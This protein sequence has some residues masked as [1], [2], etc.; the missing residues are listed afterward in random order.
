MA[1]API[2]PRPRPANPDTERA[3][4]RNPNLERAVLGA[5]LMDESNPS[6]TLKT[7]A[8]KIHAGVFSV[9]EHQIIYSRLL[10]MS[11]EKIPTNDIAVL[12]DELHKASDLQRIEAG[13]AYVASLIDGVPQRMN[14]AEH[15]RILREKFDLRQLIYKTQDIQ[16]LALTESEPAEKLYSDLETF[17]KSVSNARTPGLAFVDLRDFLMMKFPPLEFII[18]PLLPMRGSGMIYSPPGLGK[19]HITLYM[20]YCISIGAP[21]CL[22]WDIPKRRRVVYVDGEMDAESMQEM[23]QQIARGL[24]LDVPEEGYFRMVNPDL[25]ANTTP[26][27]NTNHGRNDIERGLSAGD[28]LFLDNLSTLSPSA[29]EKETE[30]WAKIQ[31]WILDLRRS[32]IA[33]FI[34]HHANKTGMSQLGSSKKE[35]QLSC[36]IRLRRP[37]DYKME[38]GLRV[39]VLFDKMRSRGAGPF[40]TKWVQPFEVTMR[41]DDGRAVFAHRPLKELLRERALQ[42]LAEGMRPND[43]ALDTGLSRFAVARLKNKVRSISDKDSDD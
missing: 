3:T 32:G 14:I 40:K 28:L 8:E 1:T 20:A 10:A 2:R 26:R 4:P 27:I 17:T 22:V 23:V 21:T 12:I 19:T 31:E 35:H 38:D 33:T 25:Q 6:E 16:Q 30:D 7:V 39:E 15:L 34:V 37:S 43:V 9:P 13:A 24:D 41:V 5:I 11:E 18:E 29:D 36:N 42:M